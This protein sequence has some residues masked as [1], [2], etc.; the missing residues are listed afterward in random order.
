MPIPRHPITEMSPVVC[1]I[2]FAMWGIDLVGQFLKP[3]V[4]YK[5]VVVAVIILASGW[6]PPLS[7]ARQPRPSR[8]SYERISSPDTVSLNSG[9]R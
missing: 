7:K 6:K 8:S 3:P 2:L 5:D 4:R 1:P 9:V